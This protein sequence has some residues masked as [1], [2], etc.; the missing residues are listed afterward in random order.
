MNSRQYN[1]ISK[2][3]KFYYDKYWIPEYIPVPKKHVLRW[4][5]LLKIKRRNAKRFQEFKI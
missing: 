3:L 1:K 5:S 4:T 2:E